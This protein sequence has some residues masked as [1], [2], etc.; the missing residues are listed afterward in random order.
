MNTNYLAIFGPALTFVLTIASWFVTNY[1]NRKTEI[2]KASLN[3]RLELLT[4]TLNS[5]N[6]VYKIL[7]KYNGNPPTK[8]EQIYVIKSLA[9]ISEDIYILG[10]KEEQKRWK[11]II[12]DYKNQTIKSENLTTFANLIRNNYRR[13]LGL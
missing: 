13:A 5:I 4:R 8:E 12:N 2:A 7:A 10:T 3:H 6:E 1:L 9:T 11:S